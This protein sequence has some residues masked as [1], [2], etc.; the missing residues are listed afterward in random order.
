MFKEGV[1]TVGF[2][3]TLTANKYR[4]DRSDMKHREIY[5]SIERVSNCEQ[6]T[7]VGEGKRTNR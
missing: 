7:K 4:T 3:T 2:A 6:C 5:L 1:D